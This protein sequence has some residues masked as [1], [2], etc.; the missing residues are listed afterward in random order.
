LASSI[1]SSSLRTNHPRPAG[2]HVLTSFYTERAPAFPSSPWN[3]GAGR[4][5]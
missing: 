4:L 5:G 3:N 2:A 1:R